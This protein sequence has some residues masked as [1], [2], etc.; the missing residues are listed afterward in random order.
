L[1]GV[2][3]RFIEALLFLCN[4]A[5]FDR[6]LGHTDIVAVNVSGSR[7]SGGGSIRQFMMLES[8]Y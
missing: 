6:T 1:R 3:K 5:R 2:C 7:R 8:A 4:H